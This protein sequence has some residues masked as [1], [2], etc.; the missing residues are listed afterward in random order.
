MNVFGKAFEFDGVSS[1]TYNI[2]LCSMESSDHNRSSA[3]SYSILSGDITPNRPRPNLYNKKY[4]G[5]LE[6]K[7]EVCKQCVANVRFTTEEQQKLVRW[8]TSPYDYRKFKITDFEDSDY[9]TGVEYFCMC[10]NYGETVINDNILG[11]FF[12]FQ[13][14]AP[15]AFLEEEITEFTST[16]SASATFTIDNKSDE[17]EEDYYPIIELTGT[18]SGKVTITNSSYHNEVMELSILDGQTLYIDNE[19]SDISDDMDMFEYSTDTNLVW[20]RLAPGNNI[21]TIAGDC[22]G[23]VKCMYPRKVGI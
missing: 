4:N 20:L 7:I 22:T 1:E 8:F 13:C 23:S 18:A 5:V 3:I 11:M 17:L 14:N 16:S 21:I 12:E 6:F 9:H 15:Y 2:I 19:E 10:T